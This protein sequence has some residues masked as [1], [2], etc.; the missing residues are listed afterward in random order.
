MRETASYRRLFIVV[1]LVTAVC[2]AGHYSGATVPVERVILRGASSVGT[3]SVSL[4]ARTHTSTASSQRITDLEQRVADLMTE[5]VKLRSDIA[6]INE[7]TEQQQFITSNALHGI[8]ARIFARSADP[9]SSYVVINRGAQQGITVGQPVITGNGVC[10]GKVISTTDDTARVLLTTD[11][12]SSFS[13]V[14]ATDSNAQG[15]VSGAQGLSL[16]M[17]LIPQSVTLTIHDTIITSG[18][19]PLIPRGL[20]LGDIERG[21]QQSGSLFQSATLHAPYL[22]SNLDVI[23]VI[24]SPPQ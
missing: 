1:A 17:D 3:A 21:N 15:V 10:I 22:A 23:S 4:V 11:N 14:S 16:T 2:I 5:N 18:I 24:S 8:Q 20:V 6:A 12:R 19:D 9:T 13:S 7:S